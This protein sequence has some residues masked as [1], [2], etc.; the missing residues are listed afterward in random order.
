MT[1][2][3]A[4][5]GAGAGTPAGIDPVIHALGALGTPVDCAGVRNVPLEGPHVLWLVAGGALDLFAVD[6]AE[7]GQWH[8][9]GRLEAGTLLLGP[10]DGPRHTLLSRPSQDCVLRRIALREL[11]APPPAYGYEGAYADPY[12]A[13]ATGNISTPPVPTPLEHAFALGAARGLGAL[14][15]TPL[16]TRPST[17]GAVSDDD[18]LWMP[19]SPAASSTG[20]RTA[21]KRRATCWSTARCGSG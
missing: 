9:L 4:G 15:Q 2:T 5:A 6:A 14:F 7:R 20:P 1:S 18:V 3:T 8:F 11:Y 16:D 19:V 17:D 10:V 13:A 12:G 21:R